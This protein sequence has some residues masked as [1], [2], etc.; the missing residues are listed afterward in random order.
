MNSR[1]IER[2]SGREARRS[3]ELFGHFEG[4][5]G[6][7]TLGQDGHWSPAG[8]GD[9]V[10]RSSLVGHYSACVED[11]ECG[12]STIQS[13]DKDIDGSVGT[14]KTGDGK[15]LPSWETSTHP[16]GWVWVGWADAATWL[17]GRCRRRH[18]IGC[19]ADRRKV[20]RHRHSNNGM[21]FPTAKL[22]RV[23]VHTEH[24]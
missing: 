3:N 18:P 4:Q 10:R 21:D 11:N 15:W 5:Y 12:G 24:L 20:A 13:G 2:T 1:C 19:G 14:R 8:S 23:S 17:G 16:I 7:S 22:H 6:C 9:A